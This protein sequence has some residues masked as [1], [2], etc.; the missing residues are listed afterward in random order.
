MS[1]KSTEYHR[2]FLH[3]PRKGVMTPDKIVR[4]S[5]GTAH[6]PGAVPQTSMGSSRNVKDNRRFYKAWE[7]HGA[8]LKEV[9]IE[10]KPDQNFDK[11][12]TP[13]E[14]KWSSLV[15][16][17]YSPLSPIIDNNAMIVGY[18][19]DVR[20]YDM[21][22][23]P[24]I[25][26][27]LTEEEVIK[28]HH[29]YIGTRDQHNAAN[30]TQ[31]GSP[32]YFYTVSTDIY[33]EVTAFSFAYKSSNG[34]AQ[35]TSLPGFAWL[36][37]IKNGFK[38]ILSFRNGNRTL[39]R[40]PTSP[41]PSTPPP[42]TPSS[43]PQGIVPKGQ[44][45]AQGSSSTAVGGSTTAPPPNAVVKS[46]SEIE[47]KIEIAQR[48]ARGE[49]ITRTELAVAVNY[50]RRKVGL[51]PL[52]NQTLPGALALAEQSQYRKAVRDYMDW[53]AANPT[54]SLAEKIA[55]FN[56]DIYDRFPVPD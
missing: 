47:R 41:Y 3:Y 54:S 40:Q 55:R 21:L 17:S 7:L 34:Q 13:W 29:M 32:F 30:L 4:M 33:G 16:D 44:A 50:A 14:R 35:S 27:A 22:L 52:P 12:A 8:Q 46:R 39:S 19:G 23:S 20:A 24:G 31:Y 1:L 43:P 53:L 36:S 15:S 56:R 11:V 5:Q 10:A 26:I 42:A 6:R 48:K 28:Y 2:T 25:W 49:S 45:T 9:R 51:P 38:A 18:C 37:V